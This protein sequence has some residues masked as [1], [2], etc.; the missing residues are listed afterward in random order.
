M[1]P[2]PDDVPAPVYPLVGRVLKFIKRLLCDH[3][4]AWFRNIHGDEINH[5]GCRTVWICERCHKV[6]Y[7]GEY[8]T[9]DMAISFYQPTNTEGKS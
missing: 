4:W 7:D 8:I 5:T 6:K 1:I 3:R 9:K 2:I